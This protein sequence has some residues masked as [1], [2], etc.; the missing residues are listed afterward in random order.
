MFPSDR[1]V[2]YVLLTSPPL[3]A[4]IVNYRLSSFDLHVLCAPPAFILSQDQTLL[5]NRVFIKLRSAVSDF[6]KNHSMYDKYYLIIFSL[7]SLH[8]SFS[9][10]ASLFKITF[11]SNFINLNL[12]FFSSSLNASYFFIKNF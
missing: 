3:T 2:A 9:K 4:P 6:V 12:K 1:Q 8:N 7:S 11:S 5:F 10:T